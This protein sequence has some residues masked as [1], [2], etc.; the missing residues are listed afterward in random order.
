MLTLAQLI[1]IAG[2][3]TDCLY[4]CGVTVKRLVT[5][6]HFSGELTSSDMYAGML[7]HYITE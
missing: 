2:C 4:I 6:H 1:I 3:K 5:K 7:F